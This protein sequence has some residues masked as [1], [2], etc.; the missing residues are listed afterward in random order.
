MPSLAAFED[1]LP[2]IAAKY[3]TWADDLWAR[4]FRM[5]LNQEQ[6]LGRVTLRDESDIGWVTWRMQALLAVDPLEAAVVCLKDAAVKWATFLA[7]QDI[8][9]N[10]RLLPIAPPPLKLHEIC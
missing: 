2:V 10:A 7:L 6:G 1:E 8:H 3:V 5:R 4:S 9:E